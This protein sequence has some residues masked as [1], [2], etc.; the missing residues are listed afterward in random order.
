[1]STYRD[2][3]VLRQIADNIAKAAPAKGALLSSRA[4]IY[5]LV[6]VSVIKDL[7]GLKLMPADRWPRRS[8]GRRA[9]HRRGQRNLGFTVGACLQVKKV[10]GQEARQVCE[11]LLQ[12]SLF[13]HGAADVQ[14]LRNQSVGDLWPEMNQDLNKAG[15]CSSIS[16]NGAMLESN[17][18][19]GFLV[20]M[21]GGQRCLLP[22]VQELCTRSGLTPTNLE[23]LDQGLPPG[24]LRATALNRAKSAAGEAADSDVCFAKTL[25]ALTHDKLTHDKTPVSPSPAAAAKASKT[26]GA[27]KSPSVGEGPAASERGCR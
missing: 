27:N 1:M 4:A 10:D 3:I 23:L 12:S 15:D 13:N 6:T 26:K 16:R 17:E 24:Q 11:R 8:H 22:L 25:R 7:A 18:V 19:A 2:I 5:D 20:G 14:R 21:D 9:D